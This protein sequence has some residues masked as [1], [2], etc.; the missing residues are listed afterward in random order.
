MTERSAL[1]AAR[2]LTEVREHA[3]REA[4][5]YEVSADQY[6]A[7]NNESR[8]D[9]ESAVAGAYRD[10]V[11]MIDRMTGNA[12]WCSCTKAFAS[13]RI[14]VMHHNCAVHGNQVR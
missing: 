11:N 10:I 14:V 8:M 5:M 1:A 12:P 13:E 2:A 6:A 7:T 3:V 9:E 4:S